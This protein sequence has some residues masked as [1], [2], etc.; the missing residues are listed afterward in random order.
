[1][2]RVAS[3]MLCWGCQ[4]SAPCRTRPPCFPLSRSHA[5]WLGL[6]LG[7][8]RPPERRPERVHSAQPGTRLLR[9]HCRRW[10]AAA[11]SL[12]CRTAAGGGG[13]PA[14]GAKPTARL[15]LC[16]CPVRA[17]PAFAA[18]QPA[19]GAVPHQGPPH[20]RHRPVGAPGGWA[21][22]EARGRDGSGSGRGAEG[23]APEPLSCHACSQSCRLSPPPFPCRYVLISTT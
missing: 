22:G 2:S 10:S 20:F 14:G 3:G 9:G 17:S 19:H 4:S 16:S 12:L 18:G 13:R 8:R 11:G 6:G 1:M 15:T 5:L 7:G 21:R 23:W